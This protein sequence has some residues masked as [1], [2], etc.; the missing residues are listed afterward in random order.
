MP[1]GRVCLCASGA[2]ETVALSPIRF[3]TPSD[4]IESSDAVDPQSG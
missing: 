4:Q 3:P 1:L 2:R